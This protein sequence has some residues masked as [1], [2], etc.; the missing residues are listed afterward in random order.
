M[1]VLMARCGLRVSG[2]TGLALE[3]IDFGKGLVHVRG[4]LKKLGTKH[5]FA[6]PKNDRERNVRC[7]SG[8]GRPDP[9]R[10]VP[11]AAVHAAVAEAHR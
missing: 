8:G 11:T 10:E 6:L 5:V 1:P 7:P 2:V 9:C 3:D 4:Q